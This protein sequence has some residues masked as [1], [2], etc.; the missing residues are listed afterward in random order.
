MAKTKRKAATEAEVPNRWDD[1]GRS[2]MPCGTDPPHPLEFWPKKADRR[3]T[4]DWRAALMESSSGSA[5]VAS[6]N[7]SPASSAPRAPSMTG[8]NAGGAGGVM[9]GSGRPSSK[10]AI[11]LGGSI[12]NGQ[13]ADAGLGK[14]RFGGEKGGPIPRIV[15]KMGTKKVDG[16]RWPGGSVGVVI[17]GPTSWSGG[18]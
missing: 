17:A 2:P 15:A 14:A 4:A 10:D 3:R 6:G 16:R 9:D 1:L 5:P 11:E 18:C 8:S 7:N 13:S 12:G